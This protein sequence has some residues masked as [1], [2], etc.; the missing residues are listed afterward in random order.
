M[1]QTLRM[2]LR[3]VEITME[4]TDNTITRNA[5]R[6]A[7]SLP[8]HTVCALFYDRADGI[9]QHCRITPNGASFMLP[10]GWQ[11][12]VFDV[13][14]IIRSAVSLNVEEKLF[15]EFCNQLSLK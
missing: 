9:R 5:V 12:M 7:F 4:L 3:D 2:K 11:N 14:Y 13:R 1:A 10:D 8:D 15:D 6:L